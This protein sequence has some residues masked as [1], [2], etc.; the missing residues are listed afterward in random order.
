MARK[1]VQQPGQVFV[2]CPF[3]ADYAGMFE[4]IIFTVFDCGFVPRC[5]KEISDSSEVRINK[6]QRIVEECKFGI[7]DLSRTELN[8]NGLPRINMPLELG[9]FLGAK[10]F[11]SGLL[12]DK[13]CLVLDLE[14][15]RFQQ[16]ISDIAGQDIEAHHGDV[17]QFI[18]VVRKWL[19]DASKRKSLP[20]GREIAYRYAE[21]REDL[22]ELV[23]EAGLDLDEVGFNDYSAFA[24]EWLRNR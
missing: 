5:A 9:L 16:F 22:P 8:E 7:H 21:F 18:K 24:Y 20:G 12:K 17:Q 2:N 15:F 13:V 19:N 14:R 4:A 23:Y 11:G 10:R 3:D 6:I 1:A